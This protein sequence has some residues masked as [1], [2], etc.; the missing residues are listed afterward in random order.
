M[1]EGRWEAVTSRERFWV[2][3]DEPEDDRRGHRKR[4]RRKG[5]APV[6]D[7]PS[8]EVLH[9]AN[10]PFLQFCHDGHF[11]DWGL[12]EHLKRVRRIYPRYLGPKIP[13]SQEEFRVANWDPPMDPLQY[14]LWKSARLIP[15][16]EC[17]TRFETSHLPRLV[18][19]PDR[20]DPEVSARILEAH[21]RIRK[22][23]SSVVA[24]KSRVRKR[25]TFVSKY[26]ELDGQVLSWYQADEPPHPPFV[27]YSSSWGR[28]YMDLR[29][30]LRSGHAHGIARCPCGNFF[31]RSS[32]RAG[33]QRTHCTRRC[34][35]RLRVRRF[36]QG[37]AQ[38]NR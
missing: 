5:S 19:P 36:R 10:F 25:E 32:G 22:I 24:L 3:E 34:T 9:F 1:G 23:L 29:H 2:P 21:S 18:T 31:Y 6:P 26:D 11:D 38:L 20:H 37:R 30:L 27:A 28:M 12:Y 7:R 33:D 15:R 8:F 35:V 4:Q 16:Q 17:V 13:L 14:E